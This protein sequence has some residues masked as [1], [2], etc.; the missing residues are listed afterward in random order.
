MLLTLAG[1]G[2]FPSSH[3]N[4]LVRPRKNSTSGT[5][6]CKRDWG[7]GER[8]ERDKKR[9]DYRRFRAF[10][11]EQPRRTKNSLTGSVSREKAVVLEARISQARWNLDE[12]A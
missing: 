3:S 12:R 1:G 9:P 11:P 7:E 5:E 4:R 6:C 10:V 8:G 2:G